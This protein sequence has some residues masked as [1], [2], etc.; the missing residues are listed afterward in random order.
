MIE[1]FEGQPYGLIELHL[2]FWKSHFFC[3][4]APNRMLT[5]TGGRLYKGAVVSN[6]KSSVWVLALPACSCVTLGSLHITSLSFHWNFRGTSFSA[7]K[8]QPLDYE[9]NAICYSADWNIRKIC[10]FNI[11]NAHFHFNYPGL[12]S[13]CGTPGVGAREM[14]LL[15]DVC[16]VNKQTNSSIEICL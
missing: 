11:Y 5:I 1:T 12:Q 16:R 3:E 13:R 4:F 14:L 15:C 6:Q 7:P 2:L 10:I 9:E 8:Q